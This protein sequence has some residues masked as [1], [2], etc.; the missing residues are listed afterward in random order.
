ME[1][2]LGSKKM[3]PAKNATKAGKFPQAGLPARAD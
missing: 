1:V 3:F 2:M